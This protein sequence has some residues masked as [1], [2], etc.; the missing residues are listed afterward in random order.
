MSLPADHE[1]SAVAEQSGGSEDGALVQREG[2]ANAGC[3]EK[4]AS[5][6]LKVFFVTSGA[7]L[8]ARLRHMRGAFVVSAHWEDR[9][10]IRRT[11]TRTYCIVCNDDA[12]KH[13]HVL[14][15]E[16]KL[17]FLGAMDPGMVI[18]EKAK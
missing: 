4:R 13:V 7:A 11:L 18:V 8:Q 5:T 1:A 2:D 16:G 6:G 3:S 10:T 12:W 14:R 17:K 9:Y 15:K